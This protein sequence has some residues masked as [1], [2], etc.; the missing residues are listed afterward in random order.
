MN[1]Q[2]PGFFHKKLLRLG[3]GLL[4]GGGI[5]ASA[6]DL[7]GGGGGGGG[8]TS[9]VQP[10]SRPG[11]QQGYVLKHLGLAGGRHG[12]ISHLGKLLRGTGGHRTVKQALLSELGFGSGPCEG[13]EVRDATGNCVQFQ[14][15]SPREMQEGGFEAV[16][17]AFGMPAF[18]PARRD[19]LTWTCP[20]GMVL[21]RDNL[22]Y[23]KQ[24]LRRDSKFR[25][26]R[27]GMRPVLTGGERRGISKARRSITRAR[28]ATAGL[29]VTV[30]KK[31]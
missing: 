1:E 22:C 13:G 23:P 3:L 12:G 29:G 30:Q 26:W 27:P 21:G 5:A 28:E 14:T 2:A 11:G 6:L 15:T 4:P 19:V 10:V 8:S 9:T 20:T 24:V 31:K 17:G 7:I 25:K 16:A 18:A